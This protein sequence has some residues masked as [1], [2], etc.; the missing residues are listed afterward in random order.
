M[1]MNQYT[2]KYSNKRIPEYDI[3]IEKSMRKDTYVENIFM[4]FG[5]I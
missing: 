4:P 5:I 2:L 3:K 1:D